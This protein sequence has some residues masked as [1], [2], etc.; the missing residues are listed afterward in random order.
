MRV[1]D[2]DVLCVIYFDDFVFVHVFTLASLHTYVYM[3]TI[4]LLVNRLLYKTTW[5]VVFVF[6][7]FVG[8]WGCG[9]FWVL[10]FWWLRAVFIYAT[11]Y[12]R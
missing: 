6:L 8:V 2:G 10:L 9:V 5:S 4:L 1:Y 12:I 7:V 11:V 3:L